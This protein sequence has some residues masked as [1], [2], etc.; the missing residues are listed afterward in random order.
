MCAYLYNDCA[1]VSV[2]IGQSLYLCVQVR[3]YKYSKKDQRVIYLHTEKKPTTKTNK[4]K[5][6][7]K[8]TKNLITWLK[9]LCLCFIQCS[10][11][12]PQLHLPLASFE[13]PHLTQTVIRWCSS[14]ETITYPVYYMDNIC[15]AGWRDNGGDQNCNIREYRKVN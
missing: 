5:Q 10:H 12:A 13:L 4:T 14:R 6:K 8:P 15:C 9:L 2:K 7:K 1:I 11:L 3:T